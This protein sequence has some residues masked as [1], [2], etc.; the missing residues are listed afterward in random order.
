MLLVEQVTGLI[1]QGSG[2]FQVPDGPRVRVRRGSKVWV[3][4]AEDEPE[5]RADGEDLVLVVQGLI[6]RRIELALQQQICWQKAL[7]KDYAEHTP[8]EEEVEWPS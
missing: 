5:T 8:K 6:L 4:W 2:V 3:V 1:Y 7:R